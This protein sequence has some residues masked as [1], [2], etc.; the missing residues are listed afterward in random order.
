M[1]ESSKDFSKLT[2][3][4]SI[5]L[6]EGQEEILKKWVTKVQ[7]SVGNAKN[8]KLPVIINTIPVFI[9]NLAESIDENF[10]KTNAN[11]SNNIA[12]EH[13]SERARVTDYS[14]DNVV[15]EY[16]LLRDIVIEVISEYHKL[17]YKTFIIIQKSFDEG[18]QKAMMAFHLVFNEIRE[19]V[20]NHMTHDMRTPLTAAKLSL[21]LIL[22][23]MN[24]PH[25]PEREEQII[26]LIHRVKKNMNYSNELIQSI[27][28]QQYLK[29]YM[30]DANEKFE[31][32]EM[33]SIVESALDGLSEGS[34]NQIELVGE[35]V[36]GFW[37]K[38][39]L[40]RVV[41]NL[42]SNAIKYGADDEM[43]KITVC[44]TLGRCLVSVHN[45]GKPIPVE[46][47]ELL[48]S[49]FSRSEAAKESLKEGWGIGLALCREVTEGHAGSL[50]IESS[51]DEGTTFTVDIPMDPRG[52]ERK[53]T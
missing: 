29:S 38:K 41:E 28:D 7:A 53:L 18:I 12:E 14:P 3:P 17:D 6:V 21:D 48:F 19:N 34:F 11:D 51:L 50:G 23:K 15:A 8:L 35:K 2:N 32:S 16:I 20:I 39:A 10:D 27:L 31:E 25:S 42:I 52:L 1:S 43:V 44:S 26:N 9:K 40:R 46:E 13:G 36:F 49:N 47:R 4:I 37:D 22:K 30:V 45:K 24:K 5:R 33:M